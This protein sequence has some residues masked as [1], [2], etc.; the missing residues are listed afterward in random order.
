MDGRPAPLLILTGPPGA[1]KS[2]VAR[3]VAAADDPSVCLEAD[4]WWTTIVRGFEPPWSP[5]ADG[6]NRTVLRSVVAAARVLDAV[7][8]GDQRLGAA[9]R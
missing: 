7:A 1:G 8:R 2:T 3:I 6:Q 4:W 9:R 5:A